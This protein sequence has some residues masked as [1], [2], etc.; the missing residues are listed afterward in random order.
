MINKDRV[1]NVNAIDLLTLYT[2]IL[3]IAG[4]TVT[5]IEAENPEGIF[6]IDA[7][8]ANA[9]I[10]SEPV[11]S[12]DFAAGATAAVVYFAPTYDYEGF[13][14]E[15]AAVATTGD[16]VVADHANLYKATLATG[17]IT[18]EKVGL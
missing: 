15:G 1:V 3:A 11:K 14:I 9:V 12:L 5:A 10:A 13:K 16:E 18:I 6:V 17:A 8:P 2:R 7:D 4:V